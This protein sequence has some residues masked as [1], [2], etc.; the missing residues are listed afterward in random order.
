M[1]WWKNPWWARLYGGQGGGVVVVVGGGW[2]C[3]IVTVERDAIV[4]VDVGVGVGWLIYSSQVFSFFPC[5]P[6]LFLFSWSPEYSILAGMIGWTVVT[7]GKTSGKNAVEEGG[8]EGSYGS[9]SLVCIQQQKES[10][11]EIGSLSDYLQRVRTWTCRRPPKRFLARSRTVRT[12]TSA[13][14]KGKGEGGV[15]S[16]GQ[17][18]GHPGR[19]VE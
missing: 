14:K 11:G 2:Y 16:G 5:S 10:M 4:F 17:C 6:S 8:H 12:V 9:R 19:V 13:C 18:W 1:V 3:C 15:P 7:V